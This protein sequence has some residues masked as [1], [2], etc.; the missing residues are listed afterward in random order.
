MAGSCQNCGAAIAPF[1]F[2]R[3]GFLS[4]LPEEMRT[5][6][7]VCAKPACLARAKDWKKKADGGD[8]FPRHRDTPEKPKDDPSQGSLF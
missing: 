4:R 5:V 2:S 3:K 8:I 6:I 7:F 1:G